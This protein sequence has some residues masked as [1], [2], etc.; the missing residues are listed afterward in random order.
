M[1]TFRFLLTLSV[2]FLCS[3]SVKSAAVLLDGIYYSHYDVSRD[4]LRSTENSVACV[5]EVEDQTIFSA[6]IRTY[7]SLSN[8]TMTVTLIYKRAFLGCHNL[9]E[10]TLPSAV[11]CI[12]SQAFEGCISLKSFTVPKGVKV[13][14]ANTFYGCVKLATVS[15]PRGITRIDEGAFC[16]CVSLSS[17]NLGDCNLKQID[18]NA[19]QY[20]SSLKEISLPGSLTDIGQGAFLGCKS[21]SSVV[22]PPNLSYL[23]V[24]AFAGCSD[25]STVTFQNQSVR[26]SIKDSVFAGCRSLKS[27]EFPSLQAVRM[28][29]LQVTVVMGRKAHQAAFFQDPLPFRHTF[30]RCRRSS[31]ARP[32]A[33]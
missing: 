16:Q 23:G 33:R 32:R 10:I 1:K 2:F 25:M 26:V 20:C 14:E 17:I 8:Q 5:C 18:V 24:K 21:L 19:F 12:Q 22:L 13:I 15:L 9:S 31:E 6:R 28:M 7:V 27:I 3:T 11:N 4:I 29:F 30:P